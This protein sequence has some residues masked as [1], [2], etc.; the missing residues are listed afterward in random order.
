MKKAVVQI[1]LFQ[2][3]RFFDIQPNF[4]YIADISKLIQKYNN[5]SRMRSYHSFSPKIEIQEVFNRNLREKSLDGFKIIYGFL[6][7]T[8]S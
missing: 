5:I 8:F 7:I 6:L 2:E 3:N 4:F 1:R